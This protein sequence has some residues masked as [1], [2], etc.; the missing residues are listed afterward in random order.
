[1]PQLLAVAQVKVGMI[2][3]KHTLTSEVSP[4]SELPYLDPPL[5]VFPR[6]I[7]NDRFFDRISAF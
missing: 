4:Y 7:L 6:H 5:S 2:H 3:L 1:M